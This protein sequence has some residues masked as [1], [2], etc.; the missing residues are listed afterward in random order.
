MNDILIFGILIAVIC[1]LFALLLFAP[2]T[3]LIYTVVAILLGVAI[4]AGGVA[5]ALWTLQRQH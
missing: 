4:M 1:V 2:L 3:I 5:F